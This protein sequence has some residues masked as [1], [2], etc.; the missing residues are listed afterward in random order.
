[1]ENCHAGGSVL[2]ALSRD[3][4]WLINAKDECN[5]IVRRCVHSFRYEPKLMTQIMG[6]IPVN[7]VRA[8]RSFLNC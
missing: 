5:K 1:M 4:I 8:V 6:N 2:L 7:R 3:S